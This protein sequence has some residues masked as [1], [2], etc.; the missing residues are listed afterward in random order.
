MLHVEDLAT[1]TLAAIEHGRP[2]EIYN[3][4]DDEPAPVKEWLPFLADSLGAP[5]PRKVPAFLARLIAGPAAVTMMTESRGASNEKA[6]QELAG[7]PGTPGE[8]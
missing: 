1:A 5:P 3:V 2:G 7:L 4:V 8:S 6:K